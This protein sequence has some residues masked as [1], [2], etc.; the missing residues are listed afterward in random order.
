MKGR[1]LQD[2]KKRK[3]DADH[4]FKNLKQE[5]DGLVLGLEAQEKELEGDSCKLEELDKGHS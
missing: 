5:T 2:A 1:M 4:I 3:I